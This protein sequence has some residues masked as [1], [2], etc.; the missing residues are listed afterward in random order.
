MKILEDS[1]LNTIELVLSNNNID[2]VDVEYEFRKRQRIIRFLID[3]PGGIRLSDCENVTQMIEPILDVKGNVSGSYLLEVAS[4]GL[5]RLLKTE[6]DFRRVNGKVVKIL[7]NNS[8]LIIGR[9]EKTKDK[10]VTLKDNDKKA[11]QIP[12]NQI[13]KAQLKI[14]F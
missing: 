6:S 5:D 12:I 7:T 2:L 14:E 9:V 13:I 8:K 4:P 1:V 10:I 3:K 11:I